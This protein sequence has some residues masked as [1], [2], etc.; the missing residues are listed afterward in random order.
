MATEVNNQ[1][2]RIEAAVTSLKTV[3]SDKGVTVPSDAKIDDLPTLAS[4]IVTPK[5]ETK[6]VTP[7][8]ISQLFAKK[9]PQIQDMQFIYDPTEMFSVGSDFTIV[10][11]EQ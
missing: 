3:I 4:S 2:D 7:K 10:L 11:A 6:T 9:L 5:L 1:L 8:T